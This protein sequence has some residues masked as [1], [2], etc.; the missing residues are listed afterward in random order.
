VTAHESSLRRAS[1]ADAL[2]VAELWLRS[3]RATVT[4]PPTAH[5]DEDVRAWFRDVVIPSREVWVTTDGPELTGLM[6]LDDE[7]VEQ[8]YVAPEHARRGYGSLLLNLAQT[9]R[10]NLALWTFEAN[11]SARA[12][13]EAHGF[14]Q[15]G[16]ASSDNE[17]DAPAVCY[18][19]TSEISSP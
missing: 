5:T 7:L 2:P 16:A 18:R 1:D 8:L 14:R 12:F 19:W 4:I 9:T 15:S 3:R 17:E 13:Y 6:V 10:S 11:L